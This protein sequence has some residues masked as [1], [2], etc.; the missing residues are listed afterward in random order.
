MSGRKTRSW[1]SA[2]ASL[3]AI[4]VVVQPQMLLAGETA[5]LPAPPRIAET[6]HDVV[7]G[8]GGVLVGKLVDQ[9]G[10]ALPM[11]PISVRT[12]GKEVARA[13]TG[14]G[15][16]FE[17]KSL[18]GGVYQIVAAGHEGVYRLW[19]PKTAPPIAQ[20]QLTMISHNQVVRG[21]YAPPRNN[22]FA[23]AGQF[24]AKHPILTASAVVAAIAI[25]IAL[26]DDDPAPSTVP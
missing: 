2:L 6:P 5:R 21:Q 22:P 15:G 26:D 1:Q 24:I 23:T 13:I 10:A 25:P 17:V 16:N 3:A 18:R 8:E 4:A 11:A 9:Q 7:L 19:A 14:R 20:Q 12:A